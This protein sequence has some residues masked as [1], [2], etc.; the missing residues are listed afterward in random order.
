VYTRDS[1]HPGYES[2]AAQRSNAGGRSIARRTT[3]VDDFLSERGLRRVQLVSIDTEGWDGLVLRGMERSLRA[4]AVDVVE[5]EYMRAWKRILGE[6]SLQATL[7]YMEG[8]GYTCFWQGNKG[9]LAQASGACWTDEFHDR[10]SHRWSNLVCA[11]RPDLL[12][13][14]RGMI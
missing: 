13:A 3:T 2:V 4:R 1:G 5:F 7:G 14:F 12:A 6:R 9:A 8:V 11:H 10:I